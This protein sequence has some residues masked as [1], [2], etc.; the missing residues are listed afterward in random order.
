MFLTSL[1][2]KLVTHDGNRKGFIKDDV[3]GSVNNLEFATTNMQLTIYTNTSKLQAIK[4]PINL[5]TGF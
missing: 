5:I 3:L 4:K 2:R 1:K